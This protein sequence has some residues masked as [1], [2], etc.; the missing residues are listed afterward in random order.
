MSGEDSMRT[1]ATPTVA[2]IGAGLAGLTAA[3]A[4]HRAG[5]DVIVLEAADRVGGRAMSETTTLGSRVDLGGQWIGHD[6]HRIAA[7]AAEL[8]ATQYRMHTTQRPT[9][10]DGARRVSLGA[11]SILA[12]AT[13]LLGLEALSHIHPPQRWGTTTVADW[14]AKVPGRTPRRLLELAA[15]TS[16]CADLDRLSVPAMLTLIRLQGGLRNMLSTTGGAQESLLV[17]GIGTLVDGLAD[18]LGD[19]VRLGHRVTSI[20][21]GADGLSLT[22]TS[23]AID[24][25]KVVVTVPPPLLNRIDFQQPL[26]PE[27]SAVVARSYMGSVYKAIAVFPTPFWRNRSKDTEFMVLD[28]PGIAMF[29][30]SPPD[31]PGH[32]CMLVGGPHARTLDHLDTASRRETVLG[33]LVSWLGTEILEPVSWHEKA[34]HLDD[35]VGGGYTALPEPGTS[36]SDMPMPFTPVGDIHWAGTETAAD[37]PGYLDGAIESGGRAAHEVLDALAQRYQLTPR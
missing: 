21:E 10:L 9:I 35:N 5:V 24:A 4:L 19:R 8:G 27:R 13:F 20:V 3:R 17:E 30:T 36:G 23:G 29:D 33:P 26:P 2:V 32:L 1:Q 11:P 18:E 25:A 6:H 28:A 15:T 34:W 31:G 12:A 22:T 7:L 16:W 37:H 14:L